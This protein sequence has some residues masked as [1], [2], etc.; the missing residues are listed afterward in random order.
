MLDDAARG[1]FDG[2]VIVRQGAQ[3]TDSRQEN[4]N[5]LLSPSALVDTRPTLMINADDV[6]CSHAA[7]IG[8]MDET[9]MFYLR[10][11]GLD[12]GTARRLLIHAFV[13]DVLQRVKVPA[14]RAGLEGLLFAV[15]DDQ[16]AEIPS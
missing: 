6:K 5:L 4:R 3:K 13:V 16:P 15:P 14:L 11:R 9:S 12:P 10:S 2:T 7:T 1:V 8:Q